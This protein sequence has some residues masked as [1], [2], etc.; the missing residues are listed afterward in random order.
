[1]TN[2]ED[3]TR[4]RGSAACGTL[5]QR[6]LLS[7]SGC[8]EGTKNGHTILMLPICNVILES[9]FY[10]LEIGAKLN[11]CRE[12]N[13]GPL[14]LCLKIDHVLYLRIQSCL[15][16]KAACFSRVRPSL[17]YEH[18]NLKENNMQ[19]VHIPSVISICGI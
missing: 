16:K 3:A 5:E 2:T 4:L 12:S 9:L 6:R 10:H 18:I 7:K 14:H 13:M 15:F 11:V 17:D 8:F 19:Y 1:M